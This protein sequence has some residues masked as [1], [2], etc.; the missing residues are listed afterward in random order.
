MNLVIDYG[1]SAAKVALFDENALVRVFRTEVLTEDFLANII[2]QFQPQAGI[3]CSVK[4]PAF[5]EPCKTL[6]V[7]YELDYRLPFPLQVD[8][9]TPQTLG[10]DRIAAAVGAASQKP[11]TNLLVIDVGTAI[12]IDFVTAEGVYKGGNISPGI[13]MRFK[14]LH[15]LTHQ[16]PLVNEHGDLPPLGYNTE[17]AIRSGVIEGIVRELDSYICDYREGQEISAFLTGGYAFY[18]ESKLKNAIFADENLVLK[19]L[20]KILMH[21]QK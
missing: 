3:L 19:G 20:N 16:L 12:T 17:T 7:F 14:S 2:R 5:S 13:E 9:Q 11:A 21:Q 18:F 8:Y 4:N 15:H 1:N 10:M 6:D